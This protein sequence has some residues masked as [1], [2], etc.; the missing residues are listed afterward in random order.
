[1]VNEKKEDEISLPDPNFNNPKIIN[2]TRFNH[3]HV[4]SWNNTGK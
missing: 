4:K 1:M 2:H 3:C